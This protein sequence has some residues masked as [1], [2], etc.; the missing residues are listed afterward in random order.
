MRIE[1]NEEQ[2]ESL[3]KSL[4]GFVWRVSSGIEGVPG[5]AQILP[6]IVSLLLDIADTMPKDNA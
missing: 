3:I 1:L 6:E 4:L 5:E 2:R